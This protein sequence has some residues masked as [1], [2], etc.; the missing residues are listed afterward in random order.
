VF[1]SPI[2][3]VRVRRLG[4]AVALGLAAVLSG[5]SYYSF[6][7]ANIPEHLNTI[8]I[9]LV[10]DNTSSPVQALDNE[11]TQR[12]TDRL[13]GQTRLR[14]ET[15]EIEADALLTVRLERY[16]NE[17]VAVGGQERTTRNRVTVEAEATY[18]DQVRDEEIFARTFSS[19]EEYDP[20]DDGFDGERT[21][22]LDAVGNIAEDIFTTATSNW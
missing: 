2:L 11:L 14:L 3:R 20:L 8:A 19:F 7:G 17:P 16:R 5:C 22:A 12:L 1:I 10:V 18:Y 9:P 4:L 6:T 13:V 15:L 21:A